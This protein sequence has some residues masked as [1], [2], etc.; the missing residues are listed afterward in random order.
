[1]L[2]HMPSRFCERISTACCSFVAP[3]HETLVSGAPAATRPH[4]GWLYFRLMYIEGD[5]F[6]IL[7]SNG[8]AV[9]QYKYDAWGRQISCDVAAG[10]S[11]AAALS[12]L[13]P[14]RYRGYVYDE[15]TGLYYLRSRYYDHGIGRFLNSDVLV[16][17]KNHL[18]MFA[19][20]SNK[21][22][23]SI[24]PDGFEYLEYGEVTNAS[25]SHKLENG[26]MPVDV[27]ITCLLQGV[28]KEW[29]Y[30]QGGAYIE[31]RS[32]DNW[33]GVDCVGL[34]KRIM[35]WYF[36]PDSF[37]QLTEMYV[38]KNGKSVKFLNVRDMMTYGLDGPVQEIVRC[39][40]GE[41][42]LPLG[43]AVFKFDPTRT[44]EENQGWVHVG[45]YI[46]KT[47]WGEH[48]IIHA[49]SSK[50]RVNYILLENS[51]FTHYGYLKGI[52]YPIV[53]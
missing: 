51:S 40:C 52:E 25:G 27:F 36:T 12:T 50:N 19:Y 16:S 9:V 1:M 29:K 28:D 8:T 43:V 38:N 6:A 2:A 44:S 47:Q 14:F 46:G 35:K 20:C 48:T 21:P 32:G 11:N 13:N 18:N 3:I 26:R 15:E 24:D 7:D 4:V 5:I 42:D 45:Y 37:R 31:Y 22:V 41:Y 30:N 39:T 49:D 34:Y 53:E 23:D 17:A 33:Y 10:N